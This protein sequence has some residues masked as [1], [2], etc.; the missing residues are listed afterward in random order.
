MD[1]VYCLQNS[2]W[3]WC[4][5]WLWQL[6][7]SVLFVLLPSYMY[8][9][10]FSEHK[11]ENINNWISPFCYE[12]ELW[13]MKDIEVYSRLIQCSVLWGN[14]ENWYQNAENNQPKTKCDIFLT[15]DVLLL[16]WRHINISG[17]DKSQRIIQSIGWLNNSVN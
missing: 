12:A 10:Y 9:K 6:L 7:N 3:I 14:N 17:T 8:C 16:K 5:I 15:S 2:S 13:V 11:V 4:H 1:S